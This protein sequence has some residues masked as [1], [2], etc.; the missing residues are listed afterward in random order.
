[1]PDGF[2][3]VAP[4]MTIKQL[5]LHYGRGPEVIH[6]WLGEA[7]VRPKKLTPGYQHAAR[8]VVHRD[9]SAMGQIA[10]YLRYWGPVFRCNANGRADIKG[11]HW[12][13][14]SAV[15]TDAELTER[16]IIKGFYTD[17]WKRIAA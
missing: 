4:T 12:R 8:T 17:D 5:R 15:L 3:L 7:N 2:A 13:R 11:T 6:R 14:G 16:A 9:M 10:D 1:V